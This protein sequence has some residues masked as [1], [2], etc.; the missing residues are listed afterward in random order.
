MAHTKP[1]TIRLN[2]QD[3]VVIA[4][5]HISVG[6]R[7]EGGL[8]C[9]TPIP[10]GHKIATREIAPHEPIL[11]YGHVIGFAS[12]SIHSG[13]HVHTHNVEMRDFARDSAFSA[14]SRPVEYVP[15][16]RRA[17]FDGIVRADGRVATRNYIGVLATVSCSASVARFIADGFSREVLT[18][19]GRIS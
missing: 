11:K 15:E 10:D 6:T 14:E 12:Q 2:S 16:S 9:R 13:E 3:N 5:R 7:V 4:L 8:V 19:H 17:T 1:V 18:R